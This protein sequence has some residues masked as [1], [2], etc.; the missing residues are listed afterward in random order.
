MSTKANDS[1]SPSIDIAMVGA[2]TKTALDHISHALNALPLT[3]G[4]GDKA[5]RS[6]VRMQVLP[7][8]LLTEA[9]TFLAG[10]AN[11]YA[12]DAES[13]ALAVQI[14]ESL[15]QVVAAANNLV[16]RA[17]ST[18]LEHRGP[19]MEQALA[20]YGMLKC[21]ARTDSSVRDTVARM[22]PLVNTRKAP[23]QRKQQR[24]EAKAK[25]LAALRASLGDGAAPGL[26][27]ALPPTASPPSLAAASPAVVTRPAVVAA[28]PV[29]NS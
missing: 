23:H 24:V 6:A 2:A 7:S 26:L 14:E 9:A 3:P 21:K 22:A 20:L 11:H 1:A 16:S 17:K 25:K 4:L 5:R 10:S 28:S 27:T 19:A 29:A 15:N 12:L 13:V 8:D 18:V